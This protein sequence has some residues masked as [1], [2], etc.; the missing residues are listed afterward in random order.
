MLYPVL[1]RKSP[2]PL[3]MRININKMHVAPV[4]TYVE[5]AWA[6]DIWNMSY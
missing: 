6:P 4:L 1:N 2:I 3:S 5:T